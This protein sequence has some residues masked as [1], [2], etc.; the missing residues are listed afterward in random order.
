MSFLAHCFVVGLIVGFVDEAAQHE[1]CWQ[2]TEKHILGRIRPSSRG[3][4][5]DFTLDGAYRIW[6]CSSRG[7]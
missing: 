1:S 5:V 4:G 6:P 2:G 3:N 7:L